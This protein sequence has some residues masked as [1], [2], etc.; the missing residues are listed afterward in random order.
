M[1]GHD[2]EINSSLV[3]QQEEE[4]RRQLEGYL[5]D[6]KQFDLEIDFPDSFTGKVMEVMSRIPYG[7][8]RT[9]GEV[10]DELKTSAVAIGQACSRNPVPLIVPCHRV[11][12]ADGLGGY[13]YGI[14][15]KRRLL[16]LERQS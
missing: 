4:I 5:S 10:A 8:T 3:E 11:V 6:G 14:E 1:L 13:F 9:Y 12:A 16:E 2:I 15:L 7:E